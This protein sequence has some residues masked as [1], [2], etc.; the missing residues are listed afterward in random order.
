MQIK[1]GKYKG[2]E[3]A[4]VAQENPQYIEWYLGNIK[5]KP[6]YQ[7][8]ET[9]LREEMKQHLPIETPKPKEV[10]LGHASIQINPSMIPL[11]EGIAHDVNTI[12]I[13]MQAKQNISEGRGWDEET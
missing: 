6:E 12:K 13:I 8:Y 9:K 5:I 7:E 11:L 4:D 2:K 10:Q 3:V 1:I